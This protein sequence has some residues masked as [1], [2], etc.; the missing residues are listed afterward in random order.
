[1]LYNYPAVC[2]T[3]SDL[4]NVVR[5]S[6]KNGSAYGGQRQELMFSSITGRSPAV[7]EMKQYDEIGNFS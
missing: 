5:L 3:G 6:V 7:R 1:M 4:F 2:G